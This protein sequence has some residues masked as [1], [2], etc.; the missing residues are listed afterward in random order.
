MRAFVLCSST[1]NTFSTA[2]E[3]V[4]YVCVIYNVIDTVSELRN[5]LRI[6]NFVC[7]YEFINY[8]S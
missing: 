4:R 7:T 3:C 1:V 6:E 8:Q 2:F 5:S